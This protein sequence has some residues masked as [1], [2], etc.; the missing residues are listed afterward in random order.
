MKTEKFITEEENIASVKYIFIII[1]YVFASIFL[2][3]MLVSAYNASDRNQYML[4]AAIAILVL[5]YASSILTI[6]LLNKSIY[7]N[8]TYMG[9]L[10]STIFIMFFMF[11]IG[12]YFLFKHFSSRPKPVVVN[13]YGEF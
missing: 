5:V 4:I 1:S 7:D 12:I 6:T 2:T 3:I 11:F 10:G 9:M 13:Q 8:I